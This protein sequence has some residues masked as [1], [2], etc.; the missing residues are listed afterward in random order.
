MRRAIELARRGAQTAH[1]NPLVGAVVVNDAGDS[2]GEG[3]HRSP[4]QAHAEVMAIDDAGDAAR[5]ST[6][7]VNLEPC[8]HHGRTPPCT[9]AIVSS[10][11]RRVVYAN[12][13]PDESVLGNG[14]QVLTDAGIEVLGGLGESEAALVNEA[15]L[16]HRRLGR[17]RLTYKAAITLDGLTSAPDGSSK[18]IT[19]EE[20]RADVQRLRAESDAI[21]VGINTVIA[22]DPRLNCRLEGYAGRPPERV[23]FDSRGRLPKGAHVIEGESPVIVLTSAEGARSL[24]SVHGDRV[25]ALA[26]PLSGLRLDLAAGLKALGDRDIVDLLFEGGPTLAGALFR[27]G[28]ID[29]IVTYIAP[30]LLAG[31]GGSPLIGGIEARNISDARRLKFEEVEMVGDDIRLIG[32]PDY[33]PLAAS[34]ISRRS[35]LELDHSADEVAQ[36]EK[37]PT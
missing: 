30:L 33:S 37:L 14:H 2:V 32:R 28:L 18:W 24:S 31:N 19:G 4:G 1:P 27:G 26:L 15:Y 34:S 36:P 23:V 29:R 8:A 35:G 16:I 25:E 5:G 22:D 3:F 6:L 21:A 9:D 12:S 10:G 13:D 17:P 11:L 7:Y 20:A